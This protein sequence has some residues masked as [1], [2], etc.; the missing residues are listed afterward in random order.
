MIRNIIPIECLIKDSVNKG[1]IPGASY[2]LISSDEIENHYIGYKTLDTTGE[3]LRPDMLYDLASLTKVVGT[4][5][6]IFQLLD[7]KTILLNDPISKFIS[8][9]LYPD[10]TVEQ[11][12][13]HS[14]GLPGDVEGKHS[15]NES[16]LISKIKNEKLITEP[17][18]EIRYSDLGYILLGKII[19]KIDGGLQKSFE[20]NIFEPLKMFHTMYNPFRLNPSKIIPTEIQSS[21]GGV[22]QGT[23][24]DYKAYLM[25]GIS[26]HAGLFSTLNDLNKF[27][28]MYLNNGIYN[29]K[30]IIP[31]SAFDLIENNYQD[32]RTL[33][34]KSWTSNNFYL[35][36]TG[37]TG[38]SIA[39]DLKNKRGFVCLTNRIYPDRSKK[40]W[41]NTRRLAIGLFF[42]KQ[43]AIINERN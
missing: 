22:I 43:E 41:I 4:T 10:V 36:H 39:L 40:D 1:E 32:G 27:V 7:S 33:G 13:M 11:L 37:F 38:T 21:R 15:M 8:G 14:S 23:V 35:W 18:S 26:G 19:E 30:Q 17:G 16:Q 31:N 28:I 5:T 34:W 20:K 12:L 25:N 42:N 24:N 6:R 9:T 29:G 2:S 3:A